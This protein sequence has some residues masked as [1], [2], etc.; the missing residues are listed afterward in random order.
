MYIGMDAVGGILGVLFI[1]FVAF[2]IIIHLSSLSSSSRSSRSHLVQL[3]H[4]AAGEV[5]DLDVGLPDRVEVAPATSRAEVHAGQSVHQDL[6]EPERLH[7][8]KI[9]EAVV[10]E[11]TD[12]RP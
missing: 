10:A 2:I 9:D 6:L 1:A 7:L 4:E 11:A 5:A 12:V 8:V 3:D